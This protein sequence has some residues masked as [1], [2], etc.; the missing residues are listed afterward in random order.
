MAMYSIIRNWL[1][2]LSLTMTT[3]SALPAFG[4]EPVKIGILAFRPK[5]QMQ[6]QWQPLAVALKQAI[7]ERDFEIEILAYPALEQAASSRQLDFLI[8]NP[9]HFVLLHKTIGLS[10]PL[11]TLVMDES[12]QRTTVF[13]G[14]IFSRAEQSD[15]NV[16][17][18]IKGKTV[19]TPTA[20]SLGAYQMQAYE[21]SRAGIRLAEDNRLL[22]T[23]LPQDK[24][25][26]AVLSGNAEVGMVRTGVLESMA[27]EGKLDPS[28]VK[29]INRQSLQ[30]FPV[31]AST[32]LYPEW[33]LVSL[34]HIDEELAR[35]VVAA[36]F[37]LKDDSA[38]TR[39]MGIR[40]FAVPADYTPVV[41]LLRELRMP[42]F[43]E[44]PS[45]TLGDVWAQYRWPMMASLL[46]ISVILILGARLLL[47][48]RELES[49]HRIL[50]E[51]KQQLQESEK[52][53]ELAVEGAEEGIWDMDLVNGQMYHSPRMREMLGYTEQELPAIRE[54]W[55][56]IMHPDDRARIWPRVQAHLD[57]PD[58]EYQITM[59]LRHRDGSWHW[60]LSRGMASR[61]EHGRA[62]RFTGT[63][64]DI[65]ERM[66]AEAELTRHRD[67]LEE[68]VNERTTALSIAKEAAESASR[69]KSTLLANMSH[70]LRTPMNAIMGMTNL[71]LR[72]ATDSRQVDQLNKVTTA[73]RHLLGVIND[74]LDISRIE[75]DRLTLERIEFP[76][77]SVLE[78]LH[79]LISQSTTNKGLRLSFDIP[80]ALSATVLC[81]DPLRLG[82]ILINLA[83]N[84]AKFTAEGFVAVRVEAVEETPD[85]LMLRF[86]VQD[87]GIGIAPED[88]ARLFTSFEQADSSMT[89]KYGGSGLGLAICKRLAQFMGGSIGVDSQLGVGSTFWFTARLQ[90]AAGY[91]ASPNKPPASTAEAQLLDS[92]RGTRILLVEDEPVNQEVSRGLLEEAGL[93]VE[94]AENG[95]EAVEMAQT[96][97]YALILM[98]MQM[99]EMNGIDATLA[100]R[101]IPGYEL[102]PILG[103]TANA[104]EEDRLRC[105]EAGMNDHIGKPV[106]PEHLFELLIK[107]LIR[108]ELG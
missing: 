13:G 27:R 78:N 64:M 99:P 19:A 14:V 73:S 40:G 106:D 25:V 80:E 60:I 81:G 105:L 11:A 48:R 69:A 29:V 28:R 17:G 30:G 7:P 38:L 56:A 85:E 66:Q 94:L 72:R 47:A 39:S 75:A 21:L 63:H 41:D 88:Q 91:A 70:E 82:Q 52:R 32:R 22:I 92:F 54:A 65:T 20:D 37:M 12:G 53:F 31:Q 79:N 59:R 24:V 98:D 95:L 51:Q 68:L 15:V 86:E 87:S 34:P 45:F 35:Q 6:A 46:A 90:K 77:G 102:T 74:I 76:L 16:L 3:L 9:G 101:A 58:D 55:E 33:P 83:G 10:A 89:R 96:S 36:L 107:W 61:D 57:D 18:D 5:A 2:L 62:I 8:T 4:S 71:A 26:E 103:M 97:D 43:E 108:A 84:A 93:S 50:L 44:A 67:H 23:G 42:P 104:F 100:I 1:L 49:Q